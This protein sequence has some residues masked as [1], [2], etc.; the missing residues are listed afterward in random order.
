MSPSAEVHDVGQEEGPGGTDPPTGAEP[1]ELC[2]PW[3]SER[4]PRDEGVVPGAAG[5]RAGGHACEKTAAP[6]ISL[7]AGISGTAARRRAE[8]K[9]SAGRRRSGSERAGRDRRRHGRSI[10]TTRRAG[11]RGR[12]RRGRVAAVPTDRAPRVEGPSSTECVVTGLD[13]REVSHSATGPGAT[14]RP[15]ASAHTHSASA[16]RRAVWPCAVSRIASVSGCCAGS[17][18][19]TRG[20]SVSTSDGSESADDDATSGGSGGWVSTR[21]DACPESHIV[22]AGLPSG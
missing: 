15:F 9:L 7:G 6:S 20:A 13:H 11:A 22:R 5:C 3:A 17:R 21:A 12:G 14:T 4:M 19:A 10:E 16:A 18:R 8:K 2:L 1:G